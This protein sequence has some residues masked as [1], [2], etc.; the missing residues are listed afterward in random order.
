VGFT[1]EEINS[2]P[3]SEFVHPDDACKL[4][5]LLQDAGNFG[6][7]Y[8]L[9]LRFRRKNADYV[10]MEVHGRVMHGALSPDVSLDHPGRGSCSDKKNP[11]VINVAREYP[12]PITPFLDSVI[13]LR[14]ENER[15]RAR[16]VQ[17]QGNLV[18]SGPEE[19]QQSTCSPT[20]ELSDGSD[21]SSDPKLRHGTTNKKLSIV[22]SDVLTSPP[23]PLAS[24]SLNRFE[25][26]KRRKRT[27]KP[28][29]ERV[30][31]DCGTT[32]SPGTY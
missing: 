30:C 26:R 6:S 25:T 7:S 23:L 20:P 3:I 5:V 31:I 32:H 11:M 8:Q 14:L 9:I 4:S 27:A 24:D 10:M 2:H 15:L 29:Q 22:V 28:L 1:S 19:V 16:K 21:R 18:D 17:L 13:D 12:G